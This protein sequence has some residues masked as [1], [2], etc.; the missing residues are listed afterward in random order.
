M[1]LVDIARHVIGCH[2]TQDTWVQIRVDDVA[3]NAWPS[4]EAER[5]ALAAIRYQANEVYLHSDLAL[6]PKT[7][8]AWAS[9]NCLKGSRGTTGDDASVCVSYWVN[10]LQNLPAG[11][12]DLFV[13]L[14]PPSPPAPETVQYKVSLVGPG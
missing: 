11:I 9:W 12:P 13:T 10:L 14:N 8:A 1:D 7:R 6:M 2:S 4:S 5:E 3:S